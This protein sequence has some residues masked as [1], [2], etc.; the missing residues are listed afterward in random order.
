MELRTEYHK[1]NGVFK[2]DMDKKGCPFMDGVYSTMEFATL[3]K[4]L[5]VGTE[6]LDGTNIRL[7]VNPPRAA[8]ADYEPAETIH[9]GGRTARAQIPPHLLD[10]L[11]EILYNPTIDGTTR[12]GRM[13]E[14][15]DDGAV[16]YGEGVGPKIQK[17][18][19]NY[20][21]D[22][23]KNGCDFVLF[24]VRVGHIWLKPDVVESIADAL[25][26]RYAPQV[27]EGSLTGAILQMKIVALGQ[28]TT[29]CGTSHWGNFVAEGMV[30]RPK[31]GLLDRMGRRIIT[32][33]KV[34]DFPAE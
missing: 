7:I 22:E 23:T 14:Q 31:L 21:T 19:A 3:D 15:F 27:Y 20:K 11:M 17:G 26:L 25:E 34:K 13:C 2:R 6:K 4:A 8:R 32:K 33:L 30:L 24:D 5:W 29:T 1:I 12:A 10:D 9:I 28:A 16:L 18:G